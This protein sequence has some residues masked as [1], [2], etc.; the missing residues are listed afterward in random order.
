MSKIVLIGA[1]SVNFGLGTVGD[2]YKSKIL[3]GSTITLHDINPKTLENTK[4]IRIELQKFI[5]EQNIKTILDI[6]CGDF[7]W[8]S[9]MNLE[10]TIKEASK[11]LKNNKFRVSLFVE[12]SVQDI[13]KSQELNVD[14]VEIHTGKFCN[15][16]NEN[17]NF[18]YELKKI[19]KA[20]IKKEQFHAAT[21]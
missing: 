5:D 15:L 12:P 13:K 10:N 4:N 8:M 20:V 19:K 9:K 16:V 18:N 14:C 2:I 1:G 7:Y 11:K 6:P 21:G 17:K 3:E